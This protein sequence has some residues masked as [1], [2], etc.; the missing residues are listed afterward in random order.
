MLDLAEMFGGEGEGAGDAHLPRNR[1]YDR[2]SLRPVRQ[3][4]QLFDLG[5]GHADL[6]QE[7]SQAAFEV[8]LLDAGF[9]LAGKIARVGRLE[10]QWRLVQDDIVDLLQPRRR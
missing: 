8:A 9:Y 1:R 5:L 4:A 7:Q 6:F 10:T 3:R 2:Q